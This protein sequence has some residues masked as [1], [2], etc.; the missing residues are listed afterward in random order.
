[1]R[2]P[3]K[4]ELSRKQFY[5]VVG[6]RPTS[7]QRMA[8]GADR[9]G[10]ISTIVHEA[11]VENSRYDGYEDNLTGVARFQYSSPNMRSTY[12]T[13]HLDVNPPIYIRGPGITSGAFALESA[14]CCS[15]VIMI[16]GVGRARVGRTPAR[17]RRRVPGE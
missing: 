5:S 16:E 8:I 11:R 2:R 14:I 7:R 9:S 3:I 15:R 1:M 13:V 17:H 10:R 4:L 12:R 6:Y